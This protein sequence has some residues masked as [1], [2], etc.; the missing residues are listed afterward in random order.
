MIAGLAA[1]WLCLVIALFRLRRGAARAGEALRLMPD[2]IRLLSRLARDSS[3]PSGVR[4]R[5]WLLLAYLASPI[6]IV[7]DV[8]PVVG[9]AD[10]VILIS[11][12]LRSVI[13]RAGDDAVRRHWPGTAEG[14]AVVSRLVGLGR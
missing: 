13:K 4:I 7:P 6:D 12:V 11:L 3:L 5:L 10:D 8:I 1:V 2:V 9:L 14:F